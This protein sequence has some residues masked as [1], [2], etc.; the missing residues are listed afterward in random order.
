MNIVGVVVFP[1]VL[2]V[3]MNGGLQGYGDVETR[4][5]VKGAPRVI[6]AAEYVFESLHAAFF[7]GRLYDRVYV[8]RNFAC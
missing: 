8:E 4:H 1:L 5:S 6:D 3:P 7:S 2:G